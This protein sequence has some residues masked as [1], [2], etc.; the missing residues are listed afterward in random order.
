MPSMSARPRDYWRSLEELAQTPEFAEII[1]REVPRFAEI[2]TTTDRREFLRLM[3]AAMALGGLAA[4]GPEPEPRQY[5]PYVV[6]PPGIIEG[7][8]SSYA[9]AATREGYA[10]GVLIQHRS[11]RPVKVEGNPDHPASLGAASA[12]MQASILTLYDPRRLQSIVGN[13]QIDTWE[14]VVTVLFERRQKFAKNKG[15][16]LRLLTGNVTSPSLIAQITALQQQ[17]PEMQWH[18]WEPLHRDLEFAAA[19]ENFGR[20][21][22]RIY[23]VAGAEIVFAIESDLI[24]HAPGWLAYA[25][26]FAANRRPV[27]NGGKM[28]RVYAIESTPTL[29]GAKADHRLPMTPFEI[30]EAVAYLAGAV[31][32]GP[33]EFSHP[34]HPWT[35]WLDAAAQDLMSHRGRV[36][37]HAGREQPLGVQLMVDQIN[38]ALGAFG[39]TV[40]LIEPVVTG[41]ADQTQGLKELALDMAAG[42]I[43]TLLMLDTNPVYTAPAELDFATAFAAR[44][45]V[46]EPGALRRRD[47]AGQHLDCSL[48]ARIRGLERCPRV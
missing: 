8:A 46:T 37:V 32:A 26:Q 34:P 17:F 19:K 11:D 45:A 3:A 4:C 14:R 25:R 35:A 47:R 10:A 12:I 42:K 2:A 15:A 30:M 41:I 18:S 36:L 33:R 43:D 39:T 9:T 28:S 23:D 27:D 20:P 13:G 16:G 24:S 5:L 48:G 21:L 38:A 7:K 6:R 29:I 1:A 44:A 22:E 31:G 40:R